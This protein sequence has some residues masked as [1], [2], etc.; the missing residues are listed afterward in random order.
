MVSFGLV[1]D[2]QKILELYL[3]KMTGIKPFID[4]L[5]GSNILA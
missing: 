3:V 1:E 2:H 5:I 4:Y